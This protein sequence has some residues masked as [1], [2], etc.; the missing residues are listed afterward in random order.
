MI[1]VVKSCRAGQTDR[2]CN[3][4]GE[5]RNVHTVLFEKWQAG[6]DGTTDI[7]T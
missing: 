1:K 5:K 2:Q 6:A 3:S 4:H 7:Y